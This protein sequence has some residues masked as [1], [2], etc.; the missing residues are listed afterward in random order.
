MRLAIL[1]FLLLFSLAF[2][3]ACG[4]QVDQDEA[5][6]LENIEDLD[7][8][9]LSLERA[10]ANVEAARDAEDKAMGALFEVAE[11]CIRSL[12]NCDNERLSQLTE[13]AGDAYREAMERHDN[14]KESYDKAYAE[15]QKAWTRVHR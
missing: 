11:Y 6:R 1:L 15:Y 3:S 9:E 8:A 7:R 13:R 4:E 5:Q 14:A 12:P 2:S 10:Q